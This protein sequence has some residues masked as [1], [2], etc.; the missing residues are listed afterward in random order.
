MADPRT[1]EDPNQWIDPALLT[2]ANGNESWAR[3]ATKHLYMNVCQANMPSTDWPKVGLIT[4]F[5]RVIEIDLAASDPANNQF[6]TNEGSLQT[7]NR[8]WFLLSR[9][10]SAVDSEGNQLDLN[11][12]LVKCEV[13]PSTQTIETQPAGLVFGSGE[14]PHVMFFPEEWTANVLRTWAV[15]NLTAFPAKVSLSLK[16]LMVRT[17]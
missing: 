16:M 8:N 4:Q 7:N 1:M 9:A 2:I 17:N 10:A 3:W 5:D 6:V 15:T 12:F 13:P 14:W 11:N